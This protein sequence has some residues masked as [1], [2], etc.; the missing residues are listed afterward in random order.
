MTLA[1]VLAVRHEASLDLGGG[2]AGLSTNTNEIAVA[3]ITTSTPAGQIVAPWLT[4]GTF[5]T[6]QTDYVVYRLKGTNATVAAANI[7]ASAPTTWT[8][9]ASAYTINAN[10]MAA[11]PLVMTALRNSNQNSATTLTLKSGD[12]LKTSGILNDGVDMF[13]I[14]PGT[15]GVVTLPSTTSGN[16]YLDAGNNQAPS[17]VISA[18]INNNGAGILTLVVSGSGSTTLSGTNLYTGATVINSGT[19]SIASATNLGNGG[20]GGIIVNGN[21]A[22]AITTATTLAATIPITVNNGA[23]A[24]IDNGANAVTLAGNITGTGGLNCQRLSAAGTLTLSGTNTYTG[25]LIL[26][27]ERHGAGGDRQHRVWEQ[28]GGRLSKHLRRNPQH[29]GIQRDHRITLRRQPVGRQCE[30]RRRHPDGRRK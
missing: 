14:A 19:L 8:N 23:I 10:A 25:P 30:P 22:L 4:T 12:N 21:A 28:R 24:T 13:T 18:P 5:S 20:S 11:N 9:A 15:G 1:G 7:A 6:V 2:S 26:Y 27:R 29:Y 16:L 3:G 17:I